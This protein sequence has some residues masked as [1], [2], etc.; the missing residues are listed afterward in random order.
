[1]EVIKE[2][3]DFRIESP[4]AVTIGKFDGVHMGHKKLI[5][6]CMKQREKGLKVC[7]F[8]FAP[9]PEKFF[10]A[11][12]RCL[13]TVAEKRRI[14]DELGVDY[15]VEYPFDKETADTEPE[16]FIKDIL[17]G[18][19]H[20]KY[21]AAGSDLSYGIRGEGDSKLLLDLRNKYDY[22]ADIIDKVRIND[23]IVSSTAIRE[24]IRKSDMEKATAFLGAPYQMTGVIVHGNRIGRTI[25]MPTINQIP[26]DEKL[27]PPFGVY[28]SEAEI[29]GKIFKGITNIGVKPTVSDEKK[30]T[31]ETFL[32]NFN[33][34]VYGNRAAVRLHGFLRPEMKFNSIEELKAQMKR[35]IEAGFRR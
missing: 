20:A 9:S 21:V 8:T 7:V 13:T 5:E 28:Y 31:V 26:D 3:K 19:I 25:G 34:D 24:A 12:E 18:K 4:T 33:Q 29:E 32:Y 23:E 22:E 35:D 30:V 27:L 15:L 2:T 1:M 10:G 6:S 17:C 14:F 11:E 16:D